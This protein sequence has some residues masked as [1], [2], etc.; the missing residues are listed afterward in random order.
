M[1]MLAHNGEINTLQGNVAWMRA[2]EACLG[3]AARSATTRRGSTPIVDD[4]EQRL[5]RC[6]TTCS[7]CSRSVGATLPHAV[8]DA[9]A[10][11]VGAEPGD[12]GR[13]RARS[14]RSTPALMEPWDGPAAIT[15]HRRA[16]GRRGARSQRAASRRAGC[17]PSDGLVCC[18]SEAGRCRSTRAR[19]VHRGKLGPGQLL[20]VDTRRRRRGAR[21][22][23]SASSSARARRGRRSSRQLAR[24][25]STTL[26]SST[27]APSTRTSCRSRRQA[28]A[29]YTREELTVVLRPMLAERRGAARLDGRRHPARGAARHTS[30]PLSRAS[31]ASASREVTNPPID[32]I[33]E[34]VVDVARTLVGPR[35]SLLDRRATARDMLI[36]P[37]QARCSPPTSST[38]CA[39]VRRVGVHR[40]HDRRRDVRGGARPARRLTR[41]RARPVSSG[42]GRGRD[43]RGPARAERPRLSRGSRPIPSLLAVS[44]VHHHLI[45][46][47]L[48]TAGRP[49]AETATPRDIHHFAAG[50]LRRVRD[51]PY[52]AWTASPVSPAPAPRGLAGG[53]STRP[54]RRRSRTACAKACRR[55]ASRRPVPTRRARSSRRSACDEVVVR[56]FTD[57]PSRLGAIGLDVLAAR[58][59]ARH[60]VAF[61]TAGER[62]DACGSTVPSAT[63]STTPTAR[64]S[65]VQTPCTRAARSDE[66]AAETVIESTSR[67]PR[68]WRLLDCQLRGDPAS[69]STTSNRRGHPSRFATGAMSLGALSP[70]HTRRSPS[71]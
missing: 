26:R 58:C 4:D 9:D 37:R 47:G 48:R 41:G 50:W 18:A 14:T 56:Y 42:G 16:H 12:A 35:R 31:C 25:A 52:L 66:W 54:F 6:S 20:V 39:P 43:G 8:L 24:R 51:H 71:P 57:T 33:R 55:W 38:R 68:R 21:R 45:R 67:P 62:L 70:K 27:A 10:A 13:A 32:P 5:G 19:C 34:R 1:R 2:R 40:V 49:R 61:P 17:E 30:A 59:C 36:A 15:L 23:R 53:S 7:S 28:A 11:R 63:A 64:N 3:D 44:A 46:E 22:A 69:Q 65:Q 60:A 29:G